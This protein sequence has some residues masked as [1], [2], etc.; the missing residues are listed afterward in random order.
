MQKTILKKFIQVLLVALL[1]NSVIFYIASSSAMQETARKDMLYTLRALD[2]LLDYSGNLEE[3]IAL[4][5]AA[6]DENQNRFTI[7]RFS[8]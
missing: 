3:Q 8:A 4:L 6:S 7:I 1:L 5:E 2:S